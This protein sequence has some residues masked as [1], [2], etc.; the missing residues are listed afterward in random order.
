VDRLERLED[1]YNECG[2]RTIFYTETAVSDHEG[3]KS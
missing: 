3:E 2:W 1:A